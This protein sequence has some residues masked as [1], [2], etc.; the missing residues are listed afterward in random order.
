M[1]KTLPQPRNR[2]NLKSIIITFDRNKTKQQHWEREWSAE[3]YDKL[4]PTILEST[5]RLIKL[6]K[7]LL[8]RKKQLKENLEKQKD[9]SIEAARRQALEDDELSRESLTAEPN[10]GIKG[11]KEKYSKIQEE[12]KDRQ[13]QVLNNV[14]NRFTIKST[15]SSLQ[16]LHYKV[17][18]DGDLNRLPVEDMNG[19]LG[20]IS[21]IIVHVS[22]TFGLKLPFDL[23]PSLPVAFFRLMDAKL[24][25]WLDPDDT[26]MKAVE[27][28]VTSLALFNYCV[29]WVAWCLGVLN[30]EDKLDY[31]G[32]RYLSLLLSATQ[33]QPL[34]KP[35]LAVISVEEAVSATFQRWRL[36]TGDNLTPAISSQRLWRIL[37]AH[38][39]SDCTI[40]PHA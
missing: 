27:R 35:S 1:N 15:G 18:L 8:A 36:F 17:P 40:L 20:H 39:L 22:K 12:L 5:E 25:L 10:L 16:I 33:E 7:D 4:R 2:G 11:K 30:V 26:S 23:V 6:S 19:V 9:E 37:E 38:L 13:R 24:V 3:K 31:N 14:R 34:Q 21:Q 28:F 29:T 32:I